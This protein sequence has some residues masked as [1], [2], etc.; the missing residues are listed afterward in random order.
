M[1]FFG[2]LFGS[3][4]KETSAEAAAPSKVGCSLGVHLHASSHVY[5][6]SNTLVMI[7]LHNTPDVDQKEQKMTALKEH[8]KSGLFADLAQW[9]RNGGKQSEAQA[10]LVPV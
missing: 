7:T 5:I 10:S 8:M 4:G 3:K 6:P 2:K 9:K 1:S